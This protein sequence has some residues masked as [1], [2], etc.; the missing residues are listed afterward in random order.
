MIVYVLKSMDYSLKNKWRSYDYTF[1]DCGNLWV[2]TNTFDTDYTVLYFT[3]EYDNW[4]YS[5]IL[6]FYYTILLDKWLLN[7][8]QYDNWLYCKLCAEW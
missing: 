5:N 6:Y 8:V 4:L 3:A 7:T 1:Y 2:L